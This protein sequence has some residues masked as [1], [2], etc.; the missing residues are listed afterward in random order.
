MTR[1]R[2][3]E[4]H[5]GIVNAPPRALEA[6]SEAQVDGMLDDGGGEQS[7][8]HLDQGIT[9]ASEGSIHLMTKGAQPLKGICV[10]A[11]SMPKCAF[12]VYLSSPSPYTVNYF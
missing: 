10:H 7:I 5:E 6:R 9:M 3:N 12:L 8:K 2:L 1:F 11:V 4:S